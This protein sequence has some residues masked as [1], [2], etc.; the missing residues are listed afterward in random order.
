MTIESGAR[1]ETDATPAPAMQ[2]KRRGGRRFEDRREHIVGVATALLNR[3]GARGMTLAD[4]A[5]AAGMVTTGVSYYFGRKEAL[6]AACFEAGL[7]RMTALAEAAAAEPTAEERLARLIR[8]YFDLAGRIARGEAPDIPIFSDIRTL[9]EPY[10]GAV[11]R[12][13]YAFFRTVRGLLRTPELAWLRGD[14]AA[15][16]TNLILEQIYWLRAWLHLYDLEDYPRLAERVID[17]LLNGLAGPDAVWNP[18]PLNLEAGRAEGGPPEE[19]LIAA[20]RQI[21]LHGYKGAS[22]QRIS[23]ALKRTKGAFYHHTDAKGDLVAAGFDR[24]LDLLKRAQLAALDL[25]ADAWVRLHSAA[26]ALA[27]FQMSPRGPLMR[28][29]ALQS[30]PEPERGRVVDRAYRIARRFAGMIS[31]GAAAGVLRPVDPAVAAQMLSAAVNSVADMRLRPT[32][33]GPEDADRQYM[34]PFLMGILKRT[35]V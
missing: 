4:V 7:A 21:N 11:G 16:R 27:E 28:T 1:D 26:A 12:Q 10:Q 17:V 3:L 34:A 13:Y 30:L 29:S 5:S 14:A 35:Q 8:G 25:D 15:A 24:T 9:G 32:E 19:L 2:P 33:Y 23:A 31:D 20:T 18:R 6:A 22:V